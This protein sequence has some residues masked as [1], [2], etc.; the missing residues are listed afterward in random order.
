[1]MFDD[2]DRRIPMST[3]AELNAQCLTRV[4]SN[5]S[6][7]FHATCKLHAIFALYYRLI[8]GQCPASRELR[9]DLG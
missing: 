7:M 1:M 2:F 4:I 8:L 9:N 3:H 5:G 6:V